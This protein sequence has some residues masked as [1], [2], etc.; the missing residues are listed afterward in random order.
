[1]SNHFCEGGKSML[2]VLGH[3]RSGSSLLVHILTSHKKIKGYGETHI[4]YKDKKDFGFCA[5]NICRYLRDFSIKEEY[6]LDKVL[7]K[8]Y[9]EDKTILSKECVKVIFMLRS[10]DEALSS[11]VRNMDFVEGVDEAY[12]RYEKQIEWM[13]AMARRLPSRKW[14]Y[15]TYSDLTQ[16][17]ETVFSRL[18]SL[19]GLDTPLP[20][21]YEKNRYTGTSG[22]GD[23][24]PH[25]EAGYI[26]RN[27]D[28]KI[29][30][31]V[32][33]YLDQAEQKFKYCLRLLR[34]QSDL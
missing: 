2:F 24:G 14:S 19:L 33:P 30:P 6:I 26:K 8:W 27:I 18:E 3:M 11:I 17:T 20:E 10:P 9:L 7:H 25:I 31:R 15:V 34:K 23:P 4:N 13:Q 12:Q 5:A 16:R 29:D 28:R 1:M 21:R 32:H 22:I